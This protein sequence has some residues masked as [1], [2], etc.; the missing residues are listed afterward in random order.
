MTY[1][2]KTFC[3]STHCKNKCGRKMTDEMAEELY[4]LAWKNPASSYHMT[5][6]T[7]FC[8]ENG[9]LIDLE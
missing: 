8:D 4:K 7:C 3:G 6:Y 5:S 2:D 1:K 9:E